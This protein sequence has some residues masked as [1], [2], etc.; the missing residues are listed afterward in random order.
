MIP[1]HNA[2]SYHFGT[3]IT[4]MQ[5]LES[6]R[7]ALAE[8]EASFGHDF[9]ID[10]LP[11]SRT[12]P[13]LCPFSCM[14]HEARTIGRRKKRKHRRTANAPVDAQEQVANDDQSPN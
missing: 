5:V 14:L 12:S 13:L 2:H 4:R 8:A 7:R 11:S 9:S 10:E 6:S 1:S 3:V